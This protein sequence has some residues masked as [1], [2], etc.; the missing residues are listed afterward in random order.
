MEDNDILQRAIVD[1]NK[2]KEVAMIAAERS[3]HKKF[4]KDLKKKYF[5]KINEASG[6]EDF[7]F[8]DSMLDEYD[9]NLG[10]GEEDPSQDPNDPLAGMP[11]QQQGDGLGMDAGMDGS[12]GGGMPLDPNGGMP[13]QD[14]NAGVAPQQPQSPVVNQLPGTDQYDGEDV[15]IEFLGNDSQGGSDFEGLS[16]NLDND[17][18]NLEQGADTLN[19]APQQGQGDLQGMVGMPQPEPNSGNGL[20][21]KSDGVPDN[22]F[23]WEQE[24]EGLFDSLNI[25]DKVLLEYIERNFKNDEVI[26][27]MSAKINSLEE[28]VEKLQK[29]L[30][31]YGGIIKNIKEQNVRLIAQ[32]KVFNDSSLSE[33]QKNS[34]V[35]A[36][37]KVKTMA[38]AENIIKIIAEA[39]KKKVVKNESLNTLLNK[40]NGKALAES[41]KAKKGLSSVD[42][43]KKVLREEQN[44]EDLN[45]R[46]KRLFEA[47]GIK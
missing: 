23:D 13:G 36:L 37:E 20:N 42:S 45:P 16:S 19:V 18:N 38:E 47:W 7:H 2:M 14:P 17:F 5:E 24:G 40:N 28:I 21:V 30:E 41:I 35:K 33:N 3:L 44:L 10:E 31:Q 39:S 25:S 46:T 34:I 6:L 12:P 11:G 1:V 4:S 27:E 22:H 9:L 8:D 43:N 26:K 29:G 32:N 15:E